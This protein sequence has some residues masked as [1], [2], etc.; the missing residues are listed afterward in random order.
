MSGIVIE[1][2]GIGASVNRVADAR[3][4][5]DTNQMPPLGSRRRRLLEARVQRITALLAEL[6]RLSP[7]SAESAAMLAQARATVGRIEERLGGRG[8]GDASRPVTIEDEGN[9]QP[10]VD[11]DAMERHFHSFE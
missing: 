10:H 5:T 4:T 7:P 8:S 11:H 2:P 1:F 6:G 3:A 9:S